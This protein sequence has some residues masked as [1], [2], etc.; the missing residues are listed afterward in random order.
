MPTNHLLMRL[1][2]HTKIMFNIVDILMT[3]S[4]IIGHK[5]GYKNRGLVTYL[6]TTQK[7]NW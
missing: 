2:P 4:K 1:N 6:S 3:S 7:D 5:G